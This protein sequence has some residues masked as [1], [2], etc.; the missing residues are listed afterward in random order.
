MPLNRTKNLKQLVLEQSEA[1][2]ADEANL[3]NFMCVIINT[4]NV[5]V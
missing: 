5:Q 2:V 4:F 3:V 1:Y